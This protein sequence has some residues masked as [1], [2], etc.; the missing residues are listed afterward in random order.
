MKLKILEIDVHVED[1]IVEVDGRRVIEVEA[2]RKRL[3]ELGVKVAIL[4]NGPPDGGR[5]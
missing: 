3:E 1:L 4:P 5:V 2:L